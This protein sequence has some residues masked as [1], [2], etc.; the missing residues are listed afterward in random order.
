MPL[1]LEHQDFAFIEP[2]ILECGL[3]KSRLLEELQLPASL[4]NSAENN[5]LVIMDYN[6]LLRCLVEASDDETC[7]GSSRQ[8]MVGTTPFI[9]G[10]V[11]EGTALKDVFHRLAEGY[12]VAHGGSYNSISMTAKRL[13]YKIDDTDF[14]YTTSRFQG[15]SNAFIESILFSLHCLFEKLTGASLANR[16]IKISTKRSPTQYP[17]AFLNYMRARIEFNAET[18][19][20]EYD[21]RIADLEVKQIDENAYLSIFDAVQHGDV[22]HQARSW[23][24]LVLQALEAGPQ[25]QQ[26][27]A[28]NLG[29]SLA[30]LRRRLADENVGFRDL[31]SRMLQTR[32]QRFLRA[33]ETPTSVAMSLGYSD[34]RSFSRAFKNWVGMTPAAYQKQLQS[35]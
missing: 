13:V 33:G 30:T 22:H 11:S 24:E 3:N 16:I 6:R 4:F 19:S 12:N 7:K 10:S 32:A 2:L 28:S 8:I 9:V 17:G 23:S 29:V 18:Y 15:L 25:D 26:I 35:T 21:G 14:P 5:T 27:V 34:V 1:R 31:R 20:I